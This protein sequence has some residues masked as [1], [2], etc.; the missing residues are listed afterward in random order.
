MNFTF[1]KTK[2]YVVLAFFLAAAILSLV[3]MRNVSINYNISDYLDEST[4][5]KISLGIL[6]EEFGATGNVQVMIEDV[7]RETALGVR[8]TL[9]TIPNVLTV[10]FDPDSANSYKDGKIGRA[11]V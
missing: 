5:T 3:F 4:E 2:K 7:D 6:N 9:A 11:H 10:S 8:D 1:T